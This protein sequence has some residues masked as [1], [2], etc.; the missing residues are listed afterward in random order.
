MMANCGYFCGR[1]MQGS[2]LQTYTL[3]EALDRLERGTLGC[4]WCVCWPVDVVFRRRGTERLAQNSPLILKQNLMW[5][6]LPT[7]FHPVLL[8]IDQ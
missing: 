4:R 2:V 7:G 3:P 1:M 6:R 8:Y 5:S